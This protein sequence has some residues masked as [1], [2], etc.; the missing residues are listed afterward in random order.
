MELAAELDERG[1]RNRLVALGPALGGGHEDGLVP[2]ADSEGVGLRD[3]V[4]RVRRLRGL[5]AEEPADVVLAHGGWAAQIAALAVPR[6]GPLLVWQRI[7]GFPPEVWGPARRLWWRAIAARVDI[8]VA[9]TDELESELRGLGFDKPVW[10]IPNSRRP[11]R[12]VAIDRSA[13]AA[14]SGASSAIPATFP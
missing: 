7:L 1:H 13:A 9:L 4:T 6:K 11:D 5:L 10:V 14:S 12:F 2:L 3:L 8:G